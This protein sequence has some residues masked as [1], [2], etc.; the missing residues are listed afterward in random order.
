MDGF[1]SEVST[2][3]SLTLLDHE[4][5]IELDDQVRK[6]FKKSIIHN[7]SDMSAARSLVDLEDGSHPV[8]LFYQN[9]GAA[10]YDD[11]GSQNLN[12]PVRERL[13]SVNALMDIYSV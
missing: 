1:S 6:S 3:E 7:P 12:M 13:E 5:G 9:T 11:Y 2:P 8:G 4:Y 10:R